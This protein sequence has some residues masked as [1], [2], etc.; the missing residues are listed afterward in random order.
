MARG[1]E[2][3]SVESQ[4]EDGFGAPGARNRSGR[5]EELERTR[6]RESLEATR[7]RLERDLESTRSDVHRVALRNALEHLDAELRKLI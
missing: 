6:K 4:M 5:S 1:W 2:S 7:R 3:K